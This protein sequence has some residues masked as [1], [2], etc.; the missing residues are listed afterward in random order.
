MEPCKRDSDLIPSIAAQV[1]VYLGPNLDLNA[2]HI[3][4][5]LHVTRFAGYARGNGVWILEL[6]GILAHRLEVLG[7][8]RREE[9]GLWPDQLSLRRI[10]ERQVESFSVKCS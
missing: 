8:E 7:C 9:Q 4:R 10:A 3:E 6:K 5:S 2:C 1:D